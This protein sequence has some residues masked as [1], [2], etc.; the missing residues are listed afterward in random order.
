MPYG[1][2]G[3]PLKHEPALLYDFRRGKLLVDVLALPTRK[4]R[5][6]AVMHLCAAWH[7]DIDPGDESDIYDRAVSSLARHCKKRYGGRIVIENLWTAK[8]E[9]VD[10]HH[11]TVVRF[12]DVVVSVR[13]ATTPPAKAVEYVLEDDNFTDLERALIAKITHLMENVL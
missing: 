3:R 12:C 1:K 13:P 2:P 9:I 6:Q 10:G 4:E 11:K 7:V 8:L 5:W